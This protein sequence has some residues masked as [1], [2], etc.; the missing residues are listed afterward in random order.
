VRALLAALGV[1][2]ALA[3]LALGRAPSSRLTRSRVGGPGATA[4]PPPEPSTLPVDPAGIR[5]LFRF[6]DAQAPVAGPARRSSASSGDGPL[7]PSSTT[8]L[9]LVGLLHRGGR[10][11]AAL[12]ADGEVEIAG[13][14]EAAAGVTVLSVGEDRVRVR[15]ADGREETLVLP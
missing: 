7:S 2:V 9:R 13:P 5:D 10:L 8:G 3:A 12:A 15:R 6:G 14:G 11:V 1:V 4:A